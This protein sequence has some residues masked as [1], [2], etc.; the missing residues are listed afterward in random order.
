MKITYNVSIPESRQQD[1]LLQV[2]KKFMESDYKNMALDYSEENL[3]PTKVSSK[4]S[5]VK[6]KLRTLGVKYGDVSVIQRKSCV[7]VIKNKIE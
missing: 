5:N 3:I 2:L 7:Y 4:V 1:A 6:T